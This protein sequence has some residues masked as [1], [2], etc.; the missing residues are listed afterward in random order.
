M[1]LID[2]E[3]LRKQHPNADIKEMGQGVNV[4]GIGNRLV[5]TRAFGNH[6]HIYLV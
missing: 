6:R 3:F 4:R 5:I 2:R 1:T